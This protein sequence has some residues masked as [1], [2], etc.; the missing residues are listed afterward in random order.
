MRMIIGVDVGG[1][2]ISGGFVTSE[3]K[4]VDVVQVA[5]HRD[6]RGT[7]VE[8][9]L[10]VVDG[11]VGDAAAR[12]FTPLGIGVGL[13]GPI[14]AA[15]GTMRSREN[16]IPEFHLVPL[17]ERI[18]ART[19]L[20][21]F[22]D[23]DV[24]ALALAEW[25]FGLGRGTASLVLLAIGTGMGGGV[26]LNDTLVRGHIGYAGEFGHIPVNFRGPLCVCG[27]RGCLSTYV[28][29]FQIAMQARTLARRSHSLLLSLAGDDP[30]AIT[31]AMVFEAAAGGD[32]LATRIVDDACEALAAGLGS[33]VNAFNPEL[34]VVTGGVASS[35]ASLEADV[36]R[37]TATYALRP[38]LAHTQIAIVPSD[39]RETVRGGAALVLY[40]L[41]RRERPSTPL[42][43]GR[44]S[45]EA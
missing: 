44:S 41:A 22:V 25:M 20:A 39:K 24:N 5:T 27:G 35:L 11:L 19:G 7:A 43:A 34:L 38:A 45:E 13:A 32:T 8:T 15:T 31:S 16:H 21:A 14:D 26:I 42:V 18:G 3:G 17:A 30:D 2:T 12:G 33:I 23:N 6:G 36:V 29:G 1:T 9:L 28:D 40:E 37:R 10:E 4:V